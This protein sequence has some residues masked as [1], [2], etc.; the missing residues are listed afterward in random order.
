MFLL[1]YLLTYYVER[2]CK[3]W[4]D[5]GSDSGAIKCRLQH[6]SDCATKPT[7]MTQLASIM[8]CK[9]IT[10]VPLTLAPVFLLLQFT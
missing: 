2:P 3:L 1:T 6:S 5:C 7:P 10:H 4:E 8:H 9:Y